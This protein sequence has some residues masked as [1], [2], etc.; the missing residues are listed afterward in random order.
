MDEQFRDL[1]LPANAKRSLALMAATAGT[2]EMFGTTQP[3]CSYSE[4]L[5]VAI[6][7]S[8]TTIRND[9]AVKYLLDIDICLD[10]CLGLSLFA[11]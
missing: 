10:P 3:Y 1:Y 9:S 5:L 2:L 8:V 6:Q 4:S 11:R 7:S